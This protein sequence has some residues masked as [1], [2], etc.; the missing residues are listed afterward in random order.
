MLLCVQSPATCNRGKPRRPAG[1]TLRRTDRH[2]CCCCCCSCSSLEIVPGQ[3]RSA[4]ATSGYQ[5]TLLSTCPVRL[6]RGGL[7]STCEPKTH[8]GLLCRCKSKY[9]ETERRCCEEFGF[10]VR[11]RLL[12][13]LF[14]LSLLLFCVCPSDGLFSYLFI[15]VVLRFQHLTLFAF[16]CHSFVCLWPLKRCENLCV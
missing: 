4:G 10:Y 8:A 5:T 14:L 9:P 2:D 15:C 6:H 13:A 16:Y 1:T 11:G 3:R 7:T 12:A